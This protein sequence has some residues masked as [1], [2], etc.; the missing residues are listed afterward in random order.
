M[1]DSRNVDR[2]KTDVIYSVITQLHKFCN[3]TGDL[4]VGNI[5]YNNFRCFDPSPLTLWIKCSL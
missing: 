2:G 1:A 4:M 3:K 5:T